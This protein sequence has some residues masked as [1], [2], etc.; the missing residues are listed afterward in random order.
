MNL[1]DKIVEKIKKLL[2][3]TTSSNES[4]AKSAMEHAQRLMIK[5]SIDQSQM[6]PEESLEVK[7]LR[8]EYWNDAFGRPGLLKQVPLMI[9]TIGPIFGV[10][11][12]TTVKGSSI[13]RIDMIGF[14]TNID[15]TRFAMDSILQQGLIEAKA[16]YKLY[17]TTTFGDSFWEGF[18][19]GLHKKFGAFKDNAEGLVVYDKVKQHV[20]SLTTGTYHVDKSN[21]LAHRAGFEAGQKVEL[22]KALVHDNT[23][24]LLN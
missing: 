10:Y 19:L 14:Q 9:S 3:L 20:Q 4:E 12:L 23:G 16:S 1:K 21:Q 24:K 2:E 18:A 22:R 6:Y 7:I 17:R 8:S 11:G 13:Q 5:H 15:I